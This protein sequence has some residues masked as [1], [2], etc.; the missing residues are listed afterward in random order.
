MN[1]VHTVPLAVAASSLLYGAHA[2]TSAGKAELARESLEP[3]VDRLIQVVS[4]AVSEAGG[5]LAR[6]Q[7]PWVMAFSTGHYKADPL[8]AQAA[9]ELASQFVARQAVTGD[10]V[11]ARAPGR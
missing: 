9:R 4:G 5:D 11:T 1:R 7:A 2:Q 10:Q 3:S 6:S 8:G